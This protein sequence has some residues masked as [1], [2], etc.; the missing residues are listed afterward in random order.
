MTHSFPIRRS[1]DLDITSIGCHTNMWD[2]K[3]NKYH[4]WLK[5]EGILDKLAP[6]VPSDMV[7]EA[8]FPGNSYGVG[9]GLHDSSAALIPYLVSFSE[10]RSEE[11]TSELHSLMSISYAVFCL[12]KK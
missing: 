3:Q 11:H 5:K 4:E 6:I 2:F 10:P 12:T 1:S 8:T 9:T 7:V